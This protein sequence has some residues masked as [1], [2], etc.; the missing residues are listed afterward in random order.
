ME[1]K[2]KVTVKEEATIVP[3]AEKKEGEGEED[4]GPAPIGNGGKT[5]R[6]IWTQTLEV[7][8]LI[9]LELRHVYFHR[10]RSE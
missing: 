5:D 1:E 10:Q 7:K 8:F 6:Y 4:A 9:N 2:P 3:P